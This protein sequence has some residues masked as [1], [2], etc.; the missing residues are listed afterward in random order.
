MYFFKVLQTNF[1]DWICF[2]FYPKDSLKRNHTST[3]RREIAVDQ[4]GKME[5]EMEEGLSPTS[6]TCHQMGD[7]Y[8]I[9]VWTPTFLKDY[10]KSID[11]ELV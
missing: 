3:H 7:I 8:M 6:L 11:I 10:W 1:V 2:A 5:T 9:N 4:E